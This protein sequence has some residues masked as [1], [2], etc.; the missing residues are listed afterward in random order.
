MGI[1]FFESVKMGFDLLWS[2]LT[3]DPL[4]TISIIVFFGGLLIL[5]LIVNML[6]EL[7]LRKSGIL[8]IDKMPGRKFEEYL[9]PLLKA[10]GYYV[11]LT[12][13][14]GDYGADL[15]LSTKGKKIIVQAKRYKKN[16]GIK[17][18][19]EI[20]SAKSYYKA[21]ECWVITNRFFT[22]QGKILAASNQV[23]LV[24]RKQLMKWILKENKGV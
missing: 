19:Q 22:E 9:K 8:E 23:R 14:S 15:I 16:V 1:G 21:D 11:Q 2:M 7:R 18:I 5:A 10:R 24:D 17:A 3:A 4:V 20:V 12:P 6:R 13:A